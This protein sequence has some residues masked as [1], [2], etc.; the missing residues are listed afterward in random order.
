MWGDRVLDKVTAYITRRRGAVAQLLVFQDPGH[1]DFALVVPGGTVDQ[2]EQ[3]ENALLR[4][5]REESGLESKGGF[6]FSCSNYNM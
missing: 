4:E 6:P 3:L 2:G 1:A 5:V